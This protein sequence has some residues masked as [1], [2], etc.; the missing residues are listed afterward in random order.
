MGAAW[1]CM[2]AA[3]VLHGQ[4]KMELVCSHNL[5]RISLKLAGVLTA[6]QQMSAAWKIAMQLFVFLQLQ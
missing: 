3:W 2:G 6:W 1:V 5:L 4:R